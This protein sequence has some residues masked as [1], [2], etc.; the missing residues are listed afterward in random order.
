MIAQVTATDLHAHH[1][2]STADGGGPRR[3]WQGV[4]LLGNLSIDGGHL[5]QRHQGE[6]R[7]S[8]SLASEQGIAALLPKSGPDAAAPGLASR[9]L[10]CRLGVGVVNSVHALHSRPCLQ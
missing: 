5:G 4:D 6:G 2:H 7:S 1:S 10:L 9:K 8:C 3:C